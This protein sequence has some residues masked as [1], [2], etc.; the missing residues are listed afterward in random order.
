MMPL[1]VY[2]LGNVLADEA[3]IHIPFYGLIGNLFITI[4][5]CIVG[6]LLNVFIPK[7]K[8]K[9]VKI[10]KPLAILNIISI[11]AFMLYVKA[12][13]FK[14]IRIKDWLTLGLI[15]GTGFVLS[16]LI[17]FVCCLPKKQIITV[18][19][20]TSIQN[21][22]IPSLIIFTNFPSPES[23]YAM[24]PLL[25]I[26]LYTAVPLSFILIS[27]ETFKYVRKKL[28]HDK[29]NPPTSSS[30]GDVEIKIHFES[31]SVPLNSNQVKN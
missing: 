22:F 2:T 18:S 24:V 25:G 27:K 12:Y 21:F 9:V 7:M 19:I 3:N 5:P 11:V 10:A 6:L 1:W 15:P 29:T 14:I 13:I 30:N 4:V 28:K 26:S 8:P 20:E 31:E 17:A 16:S 23:D